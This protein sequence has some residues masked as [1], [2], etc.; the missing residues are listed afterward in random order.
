MIFIPT[1]KSFIACSDN[2]TVPDTQ[3]GTSEKAEYYRVLECTDNLHWLS[4]E[5]KQISQC[6]D[7][8]WSP[9]LDICDTGEF[10]T[11]TYH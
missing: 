2:P 1:D 4:G 5:V 10:N 11:F 9:V 6:I 8:K 7:E 3:E